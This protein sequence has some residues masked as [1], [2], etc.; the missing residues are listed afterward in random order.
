[1]PLDASRT[2][3]HMV[4]ECLIKISVFSV[5]D[6]MHAC[7]QLLKILVK[8]RAGCITIWLYLCLSL[9][10]TLSMQPHEHLINGGTLVTV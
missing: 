1:M 3:V 10:H 6:T 9:K 8:G 7:I 4:V 5:N 2:I